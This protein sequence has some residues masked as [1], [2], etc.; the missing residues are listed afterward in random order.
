MAKSIYPPAMRQRHYPPGPG[1]AGF[2]RFWMVLGGAA[3]HRCIQV[4]GDGEGGDASAIAGEKELWKSC[5]EDR[6]VRD[7]FRLLAEPD[8]RVS[9]SRTRMFFGTYVLVGLAFVYVVLHRHGVVR[10]YLFP[11]PI[12]IS[13]LSARWAM[14]RTT[15]A[16]RQFQSRIGVVA[17]LIGVEVLMSVLWQI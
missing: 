8:E 17:M 15:Y 2:G 7:M 5:V 3:L 10:P 16:A 11:I 1:N 13:G 14:S 4:P 12:V 9:Q 6:I